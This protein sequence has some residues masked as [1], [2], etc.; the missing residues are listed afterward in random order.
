MG[1]KTIHQT[2]VANENTLHVAERILSQGWRKEKG[3]N[4]YKERNTYRVE[5][6]GS[7]HPLWN[8]RVKPKNENF[9][10][11]DWKL[12]KDLRDLKYK[13]RPLEKRLYVNEMDK[14]QLAAMMT[15]MK[16]KNLALIYNENFI[17]FRSEIN[18]YRIFK[19]A[20]AMS[21]VEQKDGWYIGQKRVI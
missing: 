14:Q 2:F 1:P 4:F 8:I 16:Q 13:T 10:I 19:I 11:R 17:V 21:L 7:N 9:H 6:D 3:L 5:I 18:G 12:K 15:I 20:A